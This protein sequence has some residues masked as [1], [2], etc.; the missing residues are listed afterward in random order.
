MRLPRGPGNREIL[1][2]E[3]FKSL[4]IQ[5]ARALKEISV[6]QHWRIDR[7]AIDAPAAPPKAGTRRLSESELGRRGLSVFSTPDRS[8]W[9]VIRRKGRAHL[10][11][12][13]PLGRLPHANEVWML[14]GFELFAALK[15][16]GFAR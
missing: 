13:P 12:K 4:A 16:V 15:R 11:G 6:M 9:K 7:I 14:H 5:V 1:A 10:I 3:P 8:E 2:A